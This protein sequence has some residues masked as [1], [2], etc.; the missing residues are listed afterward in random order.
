MFSDWA[1]EADPSPVPNLWPEAPRGDPRPAVHEPD[2]DYV[3]SEDN[4]G[5]HRGTSCRQSLPRGENQETMFNLFDYKES[6]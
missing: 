3:S 1:A 5:R 4:T 6:K 2:I